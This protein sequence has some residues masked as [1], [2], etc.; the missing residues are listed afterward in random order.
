MMK[1]IYF[2]AAVMLLYIV[3]PYL[4]YGLPTDI[5]LKTALLIAL[6][7]IVSASAPLFLGL[8]GLL[9]RRDRFSGFAA[10][11]LTFILLMNFVRPYAV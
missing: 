2:S 9:Y 5:P 11:T 6:G 3:A 7:S 8:L 1:Y 10:A 4:I